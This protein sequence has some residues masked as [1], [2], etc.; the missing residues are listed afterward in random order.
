MNAGVWKLSFL[1]GPFNIFITVFCYCV[2]DYALAVIGNQ[3][4]VQ[5]WVTT[6]M[7]DLWQRVLKQM[8]GKG[9]N[10]GKTHNP[11]PVSSSH[12]SHPTDWN[13]LQRHCSFNQNGMMNVNCRATNLLPS[14]QF[15]NLSWLLFTASEHLTSLDSLLAGPSRREYRTSFPPRKRRSRYSSRKT[16]V[17]DSW[18]WWPLKIDDLLVDSRSAGR[19][20]KRVRDG[21]QKKQAMRWSR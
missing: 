15:N 1:Q 12:T 16:A 3:T 19:G 21:I 10:S 9:G 6:F 17:R 7:V 14:V 2:S 18:P 8:F 5:V 13:P 11:T 4:A 20:E